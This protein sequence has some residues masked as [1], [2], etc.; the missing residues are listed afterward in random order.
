MEMYGNNHNFGQDY[1]KIKEAFMRDPRLRNKIK[2]PIKEWQTWIDLD[3]EDLKELTYYLL[4]NLV[5]NELLTSITKIIPL[6]ENND[7]M[8][9]ITLY[10]DK[11]CIYATNNVKKYPAPLFISTYDLVNVLSELIEEESDNFMLREAYYNIA[12]KL[13]IIHELMEKKNE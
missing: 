9:G 11:N 13:Q 1:L 6:V 10:M 12:H 5:F 4:S 2:D 7:L 3:N 8:I